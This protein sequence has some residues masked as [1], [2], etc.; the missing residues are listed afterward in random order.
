MSAPRKK[1]KGAHCPDCRGHRLHAVRVIRGGDGKVTRDLICS[2]CE[3]VTRLGICCPKCGECR[4][5]VETTRH[6]GAC[7]VRVKRC[8]SCSHR[9]RTRECVESGTA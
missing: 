2:A 1:T 3:A 6:R 8:L 9:F 4:L 7:T 5:G